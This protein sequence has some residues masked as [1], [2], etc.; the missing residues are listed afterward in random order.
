MSARVNHI[1][2]NTYYVFFILLLSSC[3]E[4]DCS[5][6][7]VFCVGLVTDT[8]GINDHGVNQSL[9]QGLQESNIEHAAYIESVD[10]RDYRKNISKF[11]NDKYDV[12]I[13]SGAGL[14]NNT[15]YYAELE[16]DTFFIGVNQNFDILPGNLSVI[17]FR[18]D[19]AGFAAGYLAAKMTRTMTVGAVCESKSFD[20]MFRYCDGFRNGVMYADEKIKIIVKYREGSRELLFIDENWGRAAAQE[21]ISNGADVL[22]AVGGGTGQGA[23]KEAVEHGIHVIGAE[24]DQREA[25]AEI[26]TGV[27]TS[28]WGSGRLKVQE[29]MRGKAG[30]SALGEVVMAPFRDVYVGEDIQKETIELLS[31][32]SSGMV[33]TNVP[34][35]SP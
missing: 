2:R 14:G 18:E 23:L 22:F 29:L 21:M 25:L 4:A 35:Q 19:Q 16:P 24:R 15:L 20:S 10:P 34:L 31:Q 26:R 27:I 28:F 13:T 11:I 5:H 30:K 33:Q 32:L 3:A 8:Q 6:E 7:D 9:W 1:L 17:H 12:I